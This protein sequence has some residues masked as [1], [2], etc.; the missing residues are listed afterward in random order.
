MP[1][2]RN[3]HSLRMAR[4]RW[5]LLDDGALRFRQLHAFD[6]AMHDL[7][8]GLRWLRAP[9]PPP[10]AVRC[11]EAR[12]LLWFSRAGACFVFNFH[13]HAEDLGHLDG[14]GAIC[15]PM[16]ACLCSD[17]ARFGGGV[18]RAR[19]WQPSDIPAAPPGA[20]RAIVPAQSCAV[21]VSCAAEESRRTRAV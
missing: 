10:A 19:L 18:R 21:F 11:C 7:E 9:T 15:A 14:C 13:A 6:A 8:D 2:E 16:R 3:G 4:R 12:Q 17:E 5:D 1:C 20:L